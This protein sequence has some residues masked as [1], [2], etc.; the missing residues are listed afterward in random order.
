MNTK[1]KK[2]RTWQLIVAAA[3]IYGGGVSADNYECN[4]LPDPLECGVN[5]DQCD[6][7]QVPVSNTACTKIC[8]VLMT[9]G[10]DDCYAQPPESAHAY[11]LHHDTSSYSYQV[12]FYTGSCT[13]EEGCSGNPWAYSCCGNYGP[14]SVVTATADVSP[15][16]EI[17]KTLD[18]TDCP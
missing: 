10:F 18:T 1:I 8:L 16:C 5:A 13:G 3:V 7:A 6:T 9:L 17:V 2:T 15:V 11:C 14:P 4:V 12:Q